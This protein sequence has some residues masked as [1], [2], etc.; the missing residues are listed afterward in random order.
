[1]AKV[2]SKPRPGPDGD[3][4]ALGVKAGDGGADRPASRSTGLL[5]DGGE[6]GA[7]VFDVGVDAAGDERLLAEIAAGEIEAAL[8]FAGAGGFDF[9]GEEFAEDDLLGEVFCADDDVRGARWGAGDGQT[10]VLGM[11]AVGAPLSS[12][13]RQPL[14][15][16]AEEAVGAQSAG[17]RRGLRRRGRGRCRRRLRRG[18]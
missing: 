7:G 10:E 4:V 1:M 6:R 3:V 9:L 2:S 5:E 12:A 14:F 16:E 18:R 17:A 15:G 8:D 11:R 13:H